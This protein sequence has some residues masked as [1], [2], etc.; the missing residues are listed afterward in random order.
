MNSN[1]FKAAGKAWKAARAREQYEREQ[2]QKAARDARYRQN[3]VLKAHGYHWQKRYDISGPDGY[4]YPQTVWVLL[5][6]AGQV[7]T[8]AEALAAIAAND[9][10]QADAR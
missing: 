5:D 3:M 8:L 2:A 9:Q 7:V 4:E 10:Q 1:E 6:A